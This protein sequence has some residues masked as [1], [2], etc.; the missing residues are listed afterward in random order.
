VVQ[1]QIPPPG[2]RIA[3]RSGHKARTPATSYHSERPH[4]QCV[5][6]RQRLVGSLADKATAP[7][8][9]CNA[10]V[11]PGSSWIRSSPRACYPGCGHWEAAP[12]IHAHRP[13]RR[14]ESAHA[15]VNSRQFH[16][17]RY[18][19]ERRLVP[20]CRR[21]DKPSASRPS[22]GRLPRPQPEVTLGAVGIQAK[23]I[24]THPNASVSVRRPP[25]RAPQPR[26]ARRPRARRSR[27][28]P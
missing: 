10:L 12:G 25:G 19:T 5:V 28:L 20:V 16:W 11:R 21:Q 13:V 3:G 26:A 18:G 23:Q 8:V 4:R 24:Q 9:D 7:R 17:R 14:S 27:P 15:A 1:L 22:L 2:Q 6:P